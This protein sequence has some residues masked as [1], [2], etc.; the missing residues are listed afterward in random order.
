[1]INIDGQLNWQLIAQTALREK[2]AL[3]ARTQSRISYS[4]DIVESIVR[5]D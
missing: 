2:L 3:S 1:M 5:K 4:S